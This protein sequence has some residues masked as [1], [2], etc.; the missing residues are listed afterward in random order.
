MA[1]RPIMICD[2][3]TQERSCRECGCTD[4]DCRGCIER[5][6]RPCYWVKDDLCSACLVPVSLAA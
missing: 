3:P 5:T 1:R 4:N 6:G 2:V